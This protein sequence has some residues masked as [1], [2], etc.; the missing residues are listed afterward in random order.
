MQPKL[1]QCGL[2]RGGLSRPV[3]FPGAVVQR[4]A[5]GDDTGDHQRDTQRDELM[6]GCITGLTIWSC[7][8]WLSG[9][10][11]YSRTFR[12]SLS[13]CLTA[14]LSGTKR[15][16]GSDA[17]LPKEPAPVSDHSGP[18]PFCF[19]KPCDSISERTF[20]VFFDLP[21]TRDFRSFHPDF[22]S[23]DAQARRPE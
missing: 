23:L 18:R 19:L 17:R 15:P 2:D 14:G 12:L 22:G 3:A 13:S 20:P 21:D 8:P 5:G 4:L 1:E 10:A 11:C 9:F 6:A 7:N 16:S